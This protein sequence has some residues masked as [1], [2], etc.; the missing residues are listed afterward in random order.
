MKVR[1]TR[2]LVVADEYQGTP[3]EKRYQLGQVIDLPQAL[4]VRFIDQGAA[5]RVP[6]EVERRATPGRSA[7]PPAVT[8]RP[9]VRA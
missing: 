6:E 8:R 7:V 9:R 4:A 5:V 3:L 1:F 2:L